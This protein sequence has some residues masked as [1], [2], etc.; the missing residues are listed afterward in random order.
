MYLRS[1][2]GTLVIMCNKITNAIE[3]VSANVKSTVSINFDDEKVIHKR[4]CNIMY[5]VVLVTLLL[6]SIDLN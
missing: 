3:S 1:I 5:T 4:D 2:G 6:F